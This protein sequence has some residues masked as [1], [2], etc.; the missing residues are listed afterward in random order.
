MTNI[1]NWVKLA[2]LPFYNSAILPFVLGIVIA[3]QIEKA[4]SW[5]VFIF[6]I[7]GM[8]FILVAT[9]YVGEYFDFEV[10]EMSAK[11]EKNK[12]SGG[13]QVLQDTQ[14][15]KKNVLIGGLVSVGLAGIIGIFIYWF[16]N[17]GPLTL[18]FGIIGLACGVLYSLPPFSWGKRG[19]GEIIIGFAYGWLTIATAFYLMSGKIIPL[20][21]WISLP[22]VLT[23]F[24]VILIN[25]FPDYPADKQCGKKTLVV[26][27]GKEISSYIY[28]T[29]TALQWILFSLSVIKFSVPKLALIFYLP[30]FAISVFL[31]Y[32]ILGKKYKDAAQLEKICGL[33]IVVN[34]GT[35]L[36]YILAFIFGTF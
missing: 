16:F 14:I 31:V 34:L 29:A 2:R 7:L 22:I 18:W 19:I 21:F 1:K 11:M 33:T 4:F 25:E 27:F 20:I 24:N 28:I 8:F 13:S 36:A 9:H 30:V 26:R 6:S 23:I 15:P 5:P 12:F 35:A 17:P 10:D 3:F 32:K